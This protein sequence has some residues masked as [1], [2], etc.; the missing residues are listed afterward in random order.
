MR[1]HAYLFVDGSCSTAT[2][3]GAWTAIA[4]SPSYRKI[5]YGSEYPTT[6]SRCELLPIINGLR[7]I[8]DNWAFYAQYTVHVISDS[9]YTV[10]TLNGLNDRHKNKDLWDLVDIVSKSMQVQYTWQER[11]SLYYM[12]VCDDIAGY[13]RRATTAGHEMYFKDMPQ[14]EDGLL[15]TDTP[16]EM[17]DEYKSKLGIDNVSQNKS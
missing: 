5:L 1:S 4:V 7:Y 12:S 8:R 14:P 11:N 3:I 10:K 2:Q 9:E 17:R 6:I 16:E 13:I 15:F